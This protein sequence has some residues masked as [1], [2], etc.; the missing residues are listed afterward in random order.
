MLKLLVYHNKRMNMMNG[1]KYVFMTSYPLHLLGWVFYVI[2]LDE[3]AGCNDRQTSCLGQN[4]ICV[5]SFHQ[6]HFLYE[7]DTFN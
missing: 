1:Y 5:Q 2:P 3:Y 7:R 6:L 4:S